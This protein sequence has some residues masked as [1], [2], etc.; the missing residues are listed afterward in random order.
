MV[1][2]AGEAGI[3]KSRLA[4]AF[5]AR[6]SEDG[7]RVLRGGCL[8]LGTGELPYAPFVE[9]FRA[10][11]RD[12]DPGA[13]PA[14][15]GPNRGELA[16]LMPEIR[17]R[18]D[19]LDAGAPVASSQAAPAVDD[20]FAQARLFELVLG[21]FERLA[22]VSPVVLV[23]EDLQWADP[24]SRDLLA[25]LARNLRDERVLLV[26]TVRTDEPDPQHAF[27]S[28]LAEIERSDRVDRVDLSRFDR[29]DLAKLL[30]DELGRAPDQALL[31][32]T[33]E[34]TAGNPFYAEQILAAAREAPDGA[35]PARLRDVVLARLSA[36]SEAGQEVLRVASAAGA[37]IDDEL[38]VAVAELPAPVV[39]D[40]LRE[41]VD[42]RILVQAGGTSDP[43]YVFHHALLQEV[44]HGELFPGER[45]RRHAGYAA[46]LEARLADQTA[47][48]QAGGPRP[49][50]A[51]LAYHWD[52][53]GDA[54]RALRATV[55]AGSAAERVYAYIEAHRRYLRALELWDLAPAIGDGDRAG[56]GSAAGL[57]DDRVAILVRAAET[58]V[59]TGEYRAAVDLGWR[60]IALVD[61]ATDPGRAAGLH[62]RQRWYLWEAGD[63]VAAVAA[64][65]EAE[66]LTPARPPS[67][68]R[69]RI[70]AHHA[71][72]LMLDGRL[73]ESIPVAEEAIAVA[74]SVGSASDEALALGVL[75]WDLALLGRVDEG[76]ER[77]RAALA[78]ADDL[79]GVEGIAL[80]ATNL[81]VLLDRVGRTADA[82]EVAASGWERARTLGVERTYGGLLLAI[83]AKAALALGR[84]DEADAFLRLGL[85]HD[86][87]G[88][89]G[90]RLRIQRGRLDTFRGD[91]AAATEALAAARV[92]DEA[93]GVTEDRAALLAALADLAAVG[94]R[95]TE[96]RAAVTEGLRMASGGLP[97]PALASLAA[98]GLRL[99]ADTA[100]AARGRRDEA[101]LEDARRRARDII[102][103][104][105]RVAAML[106]VPAGAAIASGPA[107]RDRAVAA[108][109]RAEAHRLE[110]RDDP[111]GWLAVA[112]AFEAIGRP[113]PAAYARFRAGGATLRER[114]PRPAATTALRSA[115]STAARLGARPLLAE[116]D[117]LARQARLDVEGEDAAAGAGGP[118]AE[119]AT[120]FDLTA[121]E[122]E[123]LG[124]IAAGWSN[125]QIADALFISRKTASVHASHIFDKLGAANRVEA[126]AIAHRLGLDAD[127][128]PPPGS[129]ADRG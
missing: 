4:D 40:A 114:G 97:D 53:A 55:D 7:V 67:A 70:L 21:I 76:I 113:Y 69:A 10:L 13:L 105:E 9:A 11:L 29:D 109:C 78:I 93:L 56:E 17:A 65:A 129:V 89:S 64:L 60:A 111:A 48:R 101:A 43:H 104:V 27:R 16:R 127:A 22:R 79:G 34:R 74:R 81:A 2:V 95:A 107:T 23:I 92:A 66:R 116:I 35:L 18:P 103:E 26:A 41:V 88:T 119:A 47:G 126:A 19:R 33:W 73:P 112:E 90:V 37:R 83:A 96:A 124:L 102:R 62:E 3:G 32:T 123:V 52:A 1:V 59:L 125:Q 25:F 20:R 38:L 75:G 36:V 72:I 30:A 50:A 51:E 15:L 115:R 57:A 45:A 110:E 86:P 54:P 58:A 100:A 121:R 24:S 108:L 14:L 128:P 80:G 8:S 120:A 63:R 44:I 77:V 85:G 118:S 106:G 61:A 68:A 39:R 71:G 42:R 12:V 122:R 91:L 46:A 31:D 28:Y 98:T 99:E 5:A 117:L 82:L 87:V 94:G 49:S 84:W 6:A